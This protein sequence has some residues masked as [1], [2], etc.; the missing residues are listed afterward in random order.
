MTVWV[1]L[2]QWWHHNVRLCGLWMSADDKTGSKHFKNV[3]TQLGWVQCTET[4]N[5][6]R[7][8]NANIYNKPPTDWVIK[9]F[10]GL[11]QDDWSIIW[12]R[13][14]DCG[15]MRETSTAMYTTI[16]KNVCLKCLLLFRSLNWILNKKKHH[17]F[18][19]NIKRHNCF[20]EQQISI[21]CNNE[22]SALSSQ[23]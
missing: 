18:Q 7:F 2:A 1:N 3:N 11:L 15:V 9:I 23:E 6:K 17:G 21:S 14:K 16:K 19:K 5:W 20:I 10:D 12:I 4:R 22:K 13:D 8:V